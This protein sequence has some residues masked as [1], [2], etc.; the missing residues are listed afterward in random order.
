MQ[1]AQALIDSIVQLG[2][3]K[4][5]IILQLLGPNKTVNYEQQ[6]PDKPIQLSGM[7]ICV[8]YHAHETLKIA[9]NEHGHCHFFLQADP[10]KELPA[11]HLVALS[12]D[13]HG[14]PLSWF[15]VNNWVTA[16]AIYDS[17][18]FKQLISR[19]KVKQ[20]GTLL[21]KCLSNM[22][23]FYQSDIAQ[24]LADS[25]QLLQAEQLR[26]KE[27]STSIYEN[28]ELY[29]LGRKDINL[30]EDLAEFLASSN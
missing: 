19:V 16:G 7:S 3:L 4:S 25:E 8:Y 18:L 30:S 5:N 27:T 20:Q 14:Q 11:Q 24:L 28:R 22:I 12:F 29:F 1:Y 17:A 10:K 15:T 23:L 2:Q 9:S 6:Y 21:Q 26:Y 13:N